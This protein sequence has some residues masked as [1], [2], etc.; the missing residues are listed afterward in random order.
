M[1]VYDIG[2]VRVERRAL[3]K[4]AAAAGLLAI[5]GAGLL[6]GCAVGGGSNNN[7]GTGDKSNQNPFG[8]KADAPMEYFNFEGGYGKEWPNF[9]ADLYKKQHKGA[10]VTVNGG[11]QL[12]QLLQ[13]RFIQGNP[14]D[15]IYNSGLDV[16]ALVSQ[17]QLQ[18]LTPLLK[19]P[20]LDVSGKTV[21]QSLVPGAT[22]TGMFADKKFA[23]A[24]FSVAYGIWYSKPLFE[25]HGWEYPNTWDD[26]LTLCAKIK[27]AGI[28]PWTHAG[29]FTGYILNPI[30]VTAQ[31]AVGPELG[32]AVD[33]LEPNAWRNQALIDS[34]ERYRELLVKGYMLEGSAALSHTQ[35]QTYWAERKV[36]FLPVGSWLESEL[37]DIAPKDLGMTMAPPPALSS[38]GKMP[39][40]AIQVSSS[41]VFIVPSQGKNPAGGM[42]FLR[43]MLSKAAS[44]NFSKLTNT[45]TVLDGYA[46]GLAL[47][48]AFESTR[49]AIAK[50]GK[51]NI[52][53]GWQYSGWY[54]KMGKAITDATSALMSGDI[55][56]D[57]WSKRCQKAADDTA[58]D[59]TIKKYKR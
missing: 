59:S 37:G 16:A 24:Y 52:L 41:G 14:P 47:S 44:L 28:A 55:N 2:G 49:D 58:K 34:A 1:D 6:S 26:M 19:A 32:V 11:Q 54:T 12:L 51:E 36:A 23:Q 50:A 57:E 33:N 8:V 17:N 29:K 46:D 35:S 22:A 20:S 9:A 31:K 7:A 48:S 13:P 27:A 40:E 45:L 42:E 3:L 43:L 39:F 10:N 38:S 15:L 21:E 18:E 53:I 4:L 56:G 30:L 5:P 25:Q